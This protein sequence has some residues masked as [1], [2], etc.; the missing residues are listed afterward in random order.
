MFNTF[1]VLIMTIE[2]T[3][4]RFIVD[5]KLGRITNMTAYPSLNNRDRLTVKFQQNSEGGSEAKRS[6]K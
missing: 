5:V 2:K 1:S 6:K 3:L 4:S